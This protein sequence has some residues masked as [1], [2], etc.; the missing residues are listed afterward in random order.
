[1]NLNV[2][3]HWAM[4]TCPA[5]GPQKL[6]LLLLAYL[7][8]EDG[9]CSP[10]FEDF[11]FMTSMSVRTVRKALVALVEQ[12]YI[13]DTGKRIGLGGS[14]KVWQLMRAKK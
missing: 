12:R 13:E 1:M 7:A 14:T 6:V 9:Q 8:D 3:T 10:T 4:N 2:N 5:S 11:E